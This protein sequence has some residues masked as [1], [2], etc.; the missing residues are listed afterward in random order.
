MER[1]RQRVDDIVK[2][3]ATAEALKPYYEWLCK[4]PVFHDDYLQTYNRPHIHLVDTDGQGVLE[5]GKKG[6]IVDG[7]E[8]DVDV[9]IYAT[10]FQFMTTGTFN[11]VTGRTGATLKE[12]WADGTK[13][14]LG[15]H[16]SDFPNLLIV[17]GP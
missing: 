10:G 4:R 17:A 11:T 12:K 14:F 7:K 15:M 5:I 9:L 8:Y 3:K 2:D 6:P 13:S 16:V 1:I